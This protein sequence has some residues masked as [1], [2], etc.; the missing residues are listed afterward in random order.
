[1]TLERILAEGHRFRDIFILLERAYY[2]EVVERSYDKFYEVDLL[3][4]TV[5]I[6]WRDYTS[7]HFNATLLW[8]KERTI[9]MPPALHTYYLLKYT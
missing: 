5:T 7:L 1:M 3:I 9:K 8:E 2:S 4:G 6:T